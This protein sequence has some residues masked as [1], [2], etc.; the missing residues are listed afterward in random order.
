MTLEAMLVCFVRQ[1]VPTNQRSAGVK[2]GLVELVFELRPI[3]LGSWLP[4]NE[5]MPEI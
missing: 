4:L 5:K 3:W 1:S 2:L